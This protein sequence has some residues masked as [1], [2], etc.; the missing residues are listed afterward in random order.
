MAKTVVG[1]FDRFEDAQ[2]AAQEL[3]DNGI[4]RNDISLVANDARGQFKNYRSAGSGEAG[5]FTTPDNTGGSQGAE[6]ATAGAV[7]GGVLGG[8]LG[9][10][11]GIGALAIPG[12]GPVL[13]AG[14]LVAALGS[15]GAGAVAGAGIGAAGGGLIGG[16]VGL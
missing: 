3:I 13:A 1:L 9:L 16:L 10:L 5:D 2:N 15:A 4:D 6:G 14:P 11:A 8:T 7:G 12:I